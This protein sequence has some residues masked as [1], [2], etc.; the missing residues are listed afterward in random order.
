MTL[1]AALGLSDGCDDAAEIK[2]S[3]LRLAKELHP[4]RNPSPLATE[5][6]KRVSEAY[7]VLSS[8][9]KRARYDDSRWGDGF[10]H[11]GGGEFGAVQRRRPQQ[12]PTRSAARRGLVGLAGQL[13]SKK[14]APLLGLVLIFPFL[15]L[16]LSTL[17][18]GHG[19][20]DGDDP[21]DRRV[22]AYMDEAGQWRSVDL[23]RLDRVPRSAKLVMVPQ[24]LCV[25]PGEAG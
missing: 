6:F 24:R 3:Y 15:G 21:S 12:R 19:L 10:H 5:R 16:G 17:S 8:P 2:R 14:S 4:D 11:T 1:Y 23:S 20:D 7:E 22:R 25:S 18:S 13:F 9:T